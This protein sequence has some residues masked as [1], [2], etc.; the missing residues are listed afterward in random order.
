MN[1]IFKFSLFY[2]MSLFFI[3]DSS[4]GNIVTVST[5]QSGYYNESSHEYNCPLNYVLSGMS[6]S[7]GDSGNTSYWCS[8]LKDSSAGDL[9]ENTQVYLSGSNI[10]DWDN[11]ANQT[12][13]VQCPLN[14]LPTGRG[15][16]GG[17]EN[18]PYLVCKN[19]YTSDGTGVTHPYV[20]NQ[21]QQVWDGAAFECLQNWVFFSESHTGDSSGRT[22][23]SC[24]S[25]ALQ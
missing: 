8:Q 25:L 19:F 16:S 5:I 22:L 1:N 20:V 15:R 7:G 2:L 4:A 18:S 17:F 9:T 6:H 23:F 3:S 12:Y 24:Q 21:S 14:M 13:S 11:R 10:N